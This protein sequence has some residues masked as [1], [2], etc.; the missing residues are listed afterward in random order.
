[1]K[2]LLVVV[3]VALAAVATAC[4]GSSTRT[5]TVVNHT[6][7]EITV[8]VSAGDGDRT[9]LL[10]LDRDATDTT[11]E[12]A[13]QGPR[14]TF[15][16]SSAGIDAG[17]LRISRGELQAKNWRVEVPSSVATRL[18]TAGVGPAPVRPD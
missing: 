18:Q 8:E 17:S 2:R 7:Y 1:M 9:P 12:V 14:W 11:E 5:V 15:W 3:T 4:G 13:D 10:T 16:F 6:E